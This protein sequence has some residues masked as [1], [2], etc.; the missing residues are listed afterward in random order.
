MS[1]S[2]CS[3]ANHWQADIWFEDVGLVVISLNKLVPIL[4]TK[5]LLYI[6]TV[7]LLFINNSAASVLYWHLQ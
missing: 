4:D 7:V 6:M 2:S 1:W 3:L 5:E